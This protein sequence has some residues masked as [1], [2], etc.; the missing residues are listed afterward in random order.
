MLP[1]G[2]VAGGH[3]EFPVNA[4]P[5]KQ[6]ESWLIASFMRPSRGVTRRGQE[7]T[8]MNSAYREPEANSS[9]I[10]TVCK[11]FNV[12]VVGHLQSEVDGN[13]YA[14]VRC[15]ECGLLFANPLPELSFTSL[16]EVYG[17]E[18]TKDMREPDED[19]RVL[20]M[21]R[22]ATNRQMDIVER[23][24]D[25]GTAL[26]VGAMSRAIQ[27]LEE[28]GWKLRMVEVSKHAAESARSRWGFDVTVSRIEDYDGPPGAFDFVKLGHVIEH[29]ADP[30]RALQN[31]ARILRPGGVLLVDTDNAGGLRTQVELAV[32][33]LLGEGAAARLV[34]RFT[35]KNLHKR[36]GR[37]IPPVHLHIFSKENLV[38]LLHETGFEVLEVRQPA[39]GDPTW[40]PLSDADRLSLAER[41]FLKLDQFGAFLGRGDLLS[42]LARKM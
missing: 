35:G 7:P 15:R 40:F 21:L 34:K 8:H 30:R 37:L 22:D 31:L 41:A 33:G 25:K 18:Y 29:L 11:G 5:T 12:R 23:F 3:I 17:E 32:R 20:R 36:Y 24:V 13:E 16:Q 10:C 4:I 39:W 9:R 28:R 38:R 42:V 26:N 1:A 2:P 27:V 14:A 19:S 6:A